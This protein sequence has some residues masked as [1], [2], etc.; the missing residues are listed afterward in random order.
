MLSLFKYAGI[1][2]ITSHK[3][4]SAKYAVMTLLHYILDSM[5]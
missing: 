1:F 3:L 2:L 4:E 5:C